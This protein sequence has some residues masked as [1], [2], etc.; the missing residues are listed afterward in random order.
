MAGSALGEERR[1][2]EGSRNQDSAKQESCARFHAS[3]YMEGTAATWSRPCQRHNAADE[4]LF[5]GARENQK[6]RPR[7]ER[8]PYE[9][10]QAEQ[11]LRPPVVELSPDGCGR[12]EPDRSGKSR[13]PSRP[14][15]LQAREA[16]ALQE[17]GDEEVLHLVHSDERIPRPLLRRLR[18][19]RK[20]STANERR[21]EECDGEPVT[22]HDSA[23]LLPRSVNE[24]R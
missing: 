13:P 24:S 7:P 2:A 1:C 11:S 14:G 18:S 22:R 16:H 4:S 20:R 6:R 21:R 8:V 3:E 9:I 10:A 5:L 15:G 17:P 12:R 23:R 19:Q